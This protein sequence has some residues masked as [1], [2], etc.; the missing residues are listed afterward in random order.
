[1]ARSKKQSP[2]VVVALDIGTS[3]IVALVAKVSSNGRMELI[4]VGRHPSRGLR[5]GVVVDIDATVDA[6]QHAVDAAEQMSGVTIEHVYVGI[7]GSHVKSYNQHSMVTVS[8]D[9][10]GTHDVERVVDDA[11]KRISI[12]GDQKP[13]H[14]L[15]QE[16]IVDNQPGIRQPVGMAGVSLEAR[17]H[18]I[19]GAISAVRNLTRCVENCNL[20]V[21]DMV[22]EQLASAEAVLLQDEKELGVCLIDIGAGTTDVAVILQGAMHYTAVIPVGGDQ[23]TNDIAAVLR[24]P[25]H[26]AEEIKKNFGCA[27]PQLVSPDEEIEVASVGDRPARCIKRHTLVDVVEARFAEIFQLVQQELHLSGYDQAIRAGGIVL[28]GGSAQI[29]G[30]IELA[31]EIFGMPVRL[32]LPEGKGGL[33]NQLRDASY[34]TGVGLLKYASEHLDG[35]NL[36]EDDSDTP[37]TVVHPRQYARDDEGL[38]DK[39]KTWFARH[40]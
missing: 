21:D 2:N 26:A 7:A 30:C 4:G 11:V 16:F 31:E 28:T 8:G 37:E 10:I 1:M 34:A 38:M 27:L 40:F 22:L 5:R 15:T 19:T 6:I 20:R 29:E 23:V 36:I 18:M 25:I 13:L 24:T 35:I 14:I 17:V 9:E 12:P 39:M 33:G 3:K 32:G